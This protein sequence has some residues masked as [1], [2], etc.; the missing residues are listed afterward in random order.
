[1]RVTPAQ[2]V[3]SGQAFLRPFK[4]GRGFVC[5]TR[6]VAGGVTEVGTANRK[7]REAWARGLPEQGMVPMFLLP[8][9]PRSAGCDADDDGGA[10]QPA[11]RDGVC[12]SAAVHQA[13]RG[14]PSA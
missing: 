13:G 14:R 6:L 7:G 9:V 1:M 2:M 5:R 10:T 12:L 11:G 3:A 4:S 8:Q